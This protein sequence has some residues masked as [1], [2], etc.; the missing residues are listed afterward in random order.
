M[1]YGVNEIDEEREVEANHVVSVCAVVSSATTSSS[2][3]EPGTRG[4]GM[5]PKSE[6]GRWANNL[7]SS[8]VKKAALGND[9]FTL[10]KSNGELGLS[11]LDGAVSMDWALPSLDRSLSLQVS[12]SRS[13]KTAWEV[14]CGRFAGPRKDMY[15]LISSSS[16]LSL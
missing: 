8:A 14:L 11:I 9:A 2:A 4:A 1:I 3:H 15:E 6:V 12:F 16:S 10:S 7:N 13:G 5:H